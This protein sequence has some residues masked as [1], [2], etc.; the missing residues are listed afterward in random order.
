MF[1]KCLTLLTLG[2]SLFLDSISF[3]QNSTA[4]E[5]VLVLSPFEVSTTNDVGYLAG[6]TLSGSRMNTDLKDTPASISVFTEEFL[7]DLGASS[8]EEILQYAGN[9]AAEFNQGSSNPNLAFLDAGLFTDSAP[10]IRGIPGTRTLDFFETDIPTEPYNLARID[11]S[12]GPNSILFGF[13]NAGGVFD[14]GTKEAKL[15]HNLGSVTMQLGSWDFVRIAT[16][17]NVILAKDVAAIRLMALYKDT[18][19]YRTFEFREEKRWTGSLVVKPTDSTTLKLMFEKGELWE[20]AG[21]PF[22]F[23]D[24]VSAFLDKNPGGPDTFPVVDNF[25]NPRMGQYGYTRGEGL[26]AT[27]ARAGV[28]VQGVGITNPYA[29]AQHQTASTLFS[30]GDNQFN[31]TSA[32]GVITSSRYLGV[33]NPPGFPPDGKGNYGIDYFRREGWPFWNYGQSVFDLTLIPTEDPGN[34]MPYMPRDYGTGGPDS[35]RDA[36]FSRLIARIEQRIGENTT[37]ELAYN[38]EDAEGWAEVVGGTHALRLDVT[39]YLPSSNPNVLIE[40]PNYGSYFV[41]GGWWGQY[42]E[43]SRKVGRAMIAHDLDLG[44]FFGR[45]RLALFYERKDFTANDWNGPMVWHDENLMPIAKN[46]TINALNGGAHHGHNQVWVRDYFDNDDFSTWHFKR[47]DNVALHDNGKQYYWKYVPAATGGGGIRRIETET[48]SYMIADQA[49]FLEN[50]LVFTVGFRRDEQNKK[51]HG[52]EKAVLLPIDHPLVQSG[53]KMAFEGIL[54]SDY[55]NGDYPGFADRHRNEVAEPGEDAASLSEE[56]IRERWLEAN[57]LYDESNQKADTFTA[58]LV[59]HINEKFSVFANMATNR[60]PQAPQIRLIPEEGATDDTPPLTEGEGRDIGVMVDLWEGKIFGRFSYFETLNKN[61]GSV[62]NSSVSSLSRQITDALK[63]GFT[64]EAGN[65]L[66]APIPDAGKWAT[67]QTHMLSDTE[68]TGFE[69]EIKA[70]LTTGWATT[71][72]YSYTDLGRSNVFPNF[73]WWYEDFKANISAD[74]RSAY[75][76]QWE[77]VADSSETTSEQGQVISSAI[78][79]MQSSATSARS[80]NEFGFNNRPHK[81]NIFS[82]YEFQEGTLKGLFVGGGMRWQSPNRIQR[83]L[84]GYDEETNSDILGDVIEGNAINNWDFLLGYSMDLGKGI[85]GKHMNL[86]IQLNVYNV[87]DNDDLNIIRYNRAGDGGMWKYA[88]NTP[89]N[90]KITTTLQF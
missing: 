80:A 17:A 4:D 88:F 84:L 77:I 57:P 63:N 78:E 39:K 16:D 35:T 59:Y 60:G 26:E 54:S 83:E 7:N 90:F 68:S 56:V 23:F 75:F 21:K 58:G 31:N 41:E 49:S 14:G 81:F 47:P 20:D 11:L 25:T 52:F 62:R 32:L 45:H 19:S 66:V 85:L 34:G 27:Q 87:F 74:G 67:N 42:A 43:T 79:S 8:T 18:N 9:S 40:N 48:D 2:T 46:G 51:T 53:Q 24:G 12:S 61:D 73:D 38:Q 1:R 82:R 55:F 33:P 69:A 22:N 36:D 76:D 29:F 37:I 5:D 72:S 64:D 13:A 6:N 15:F 28:I 71:I 10:N 86:R 65:V 30:H 50:R 44:K 89:R 3:A 70:N